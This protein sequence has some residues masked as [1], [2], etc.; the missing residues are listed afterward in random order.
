MLVIFVTAFQVSRIPR[1]TVLKSSPGFTVI[2]ADGKTVD[3][4][5]SEKEKIFVDAM[6]SYY[7]SG[8]Q[9]LTDAEFDQLKE[10][11]IW[12]GSEYATLSRNETAFL[13]AVSAYATGTPIMS[14]VEFDELKKALK[15]QGSI[16][17]TS[18]EP[19][20][21]LDTG[22]CSVTF[23]EDKFRKLVLYVPALLAGIVL[24]TG[25]TY[26]LVPATRS[27]NPLITQLLGLPVVAAATQLITERLIFVEPLIATGPC[28][29][30]SV[31]NR[32]FF[33]GILG[34]EGPGQ[35]AQVKCTNCNTALTINRDTL[36]VSTPPK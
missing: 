22:V 23:S 36:R 33:G 3:L 4:T 19:R 18:K 30:C 15:S 7:F 5:R 11:L 25:L 14:D 9:I 35:E 8:R 20:C 17:A 6:Q 24:W 28:P 21:F 34:V 27:L 16:V 1:R 29:E 13:N 10:D 31:N 2:G 12:E 32:I 26:E